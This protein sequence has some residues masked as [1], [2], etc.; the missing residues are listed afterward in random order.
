MFEPRPT[1]VAGLDEL[2]GG[3]LPRGALTFLAG[4]PGSGKT[5]LSSQMVFAAAKD[6]DHGLLLTSY[7]EPTIKVIEQ[8]RQYSFFEGDMVGHQVQFLSLEQ[9][10]TE[11]LPA[12]S[13]AI[14]ETARTLR[15]SIV[16]LDG[17]GGIRGA[18]SSGQDVRQ[19][20]H[21]LG[22]RLSLLGST[23]MVTS[24]L[25]PR[26]VTF[27][28]EATT[29]DVIL[30]LHFEVVGVRQQRW[31]E[32]IK[33]RNRAPL[34][35]LHSFMIGI[36]GAQVCPRLETSY[37]LGS[38]HTTAATVLG[39]R[40]GFDLPELD[41]LLH[42]GV[43]RETSTLLTGSPGTG[44]TL[45]GL[46]FALAGVAAG[47]QVLFA[48]FRETADQMLHKADDFRLGEH[49][50]T[51]LSADGGL[52]LARWEPIELN[53]DAIVHQIL[54]DVER[55]GARRL[56]VDSIAELN[57]AVQES[58][59]K[60][61]VANFM[62]AL[63]AGL[64]ARRVTALFIRETDEVVASDLT[65]ASDPLSVL[66]ENVIWLQQL[67]YQFQLRR[68]LSVVKMR[69]SAHD[70]SVRELVIGPPDGIKVRQIGET[71]RGLLEG[72][73]RQ[74]GGQMTAP[75]ASLRQPGMERA[76]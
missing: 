12:T 63:L 18:G 14:L 68:V 45:L 60:R 52:A 74:Q 13:D 38:P 56:V 29:A 50:R 55:V 59:D 42:G 58:G 21:G 20:L 35:G 75:P 46:H 71:E 40:A 72:I 43:N 28:P 54:D 15:P 41:E 37:D 61:R 7:A 44:K 2:L 62:A 67:R 47:E 30:G 6:G 64:R 70:A 69:F 3:G 10:L 26:D 39:G 27:F 5:I 1:G 25:P 16:V 73:A 19:F 33:V 31:I 32:A 48:G 8:L 17:F 22:A 34:P 23:F 24:E 11:G 9:F 4:P 36:D 51:A 65:L 76:T 66:A 53:P 57:R 49:L